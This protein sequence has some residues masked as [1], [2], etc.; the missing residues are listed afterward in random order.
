MTSASCVIFDFLFGR[1]GQRDAQR[2][3]SSSQIPV[4]P[5]RALRYSACSASRVPVYAIPALRRKRPAKN[6]CQRPRLPGCPGRRCMRLELREA[7]L[8][9]AVVGLVDLDANIEPRGLAGDR[10]GIRQMLP[11]LVRRQFFRDQVIEQKAL[12]RFVGLGCQPPGTGRLADGV[13]GP[14]GARLD[15]LGE[16]RT[17][18][19]PCQR[20]LDP[21]PVAV[22]DPCD[23]P[24][25]G[26]RNR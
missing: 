9:L 2:P 3:M 25:F 17:C 12:L 6:A 11:G 13:P 10:V 14:D 15:R 19:G 26:L 23:S 21:D 16:P 7:D 8:R 24:I 20:R 4:G 1:G 18:N 22:C 5:L